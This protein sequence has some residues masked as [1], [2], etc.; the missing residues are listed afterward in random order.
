MIQSN[1]T[2]S[3]HVMKAKL[4]TLF[5][6]AA[7]ILSLASCVPLA[8]GAGAGYVAHKEGYRVQT[9]VTKD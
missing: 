2:Q 1:L 4:F 9:P 7:A 3:D 8:I 5:L 6:A